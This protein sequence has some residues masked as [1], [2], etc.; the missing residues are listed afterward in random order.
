MR[1]F[2]FSVKRPVAVTMIV[3]IVVILGVVSLSRLGMDLF[4]A[5]ELPMLLIQTRYTGAGPQEIEEQVT[6]PLEAA[7]GTVGGVQ[8]ITSFSSRGS[9]MLLVEFDWGADLNYATNQMRDR[10]DMYGAALPSDASKPTIIKLDPSAMPIMQIGISGDATLEELTDYM[11]TRI[12]PY[13]ERIDGVASVNESGTVTEEI[14]VVTDPQRLQAYGVGMNQIMAVLRQENTNVSAGRVEEGL[15]DHAVRVV[16]EFT[17]I[18]DIRNLQIQSAYGGY[19]PLHSLAAIERTVKDR[20]SFV[21][22]N[23]KPGINVSLMKQ[24]DAN[25]VQTSARVRETID[26]LTEELPAGYEMFVAF[27]QADY[28][29]LSLSNVVSSALQGCALAVLILILFLRSWRST[30]IIAISIPVS[31]I[32]AFAMM[33]FTDVTLNMIS[34]GGLALGV[35]M[36]VDNSIVILENI[37]RFRQEEGANNLEASINGG[38]EVAGAVM[39]STITTIVVFLPIVFV[40]GLASQIFRQMAL[41]ITCSLLA[42]LGVSFIAVPMMS[43]K[44]LIKEKKKK[45]NERFMPWLK[46]WYSRFLAW[47]LR[48]KGVVVLFF[49]A[50]LIGSVFLLPYVGM[51]FI[52]AQ[53]TGEYSVSISLPRGVALRETLRV[54]GRVE[55]ILNEIPENER[56]MSNVGGGGGIMGLGLGGGGSSG[57]SFSGSLVPLSQRNRSIDEIMDDIRERLSVI[58]GIEYEVT[59]AGGMMMMMGSDIVIYLLGDD[60]EQLKVIADA[61]ARRLELIDGAREVSTSLE[62]G[63]PEINVY[64][65]RQKASQY[66]LN[67]STVAATVSAAVSGISPTK[68]RE[69][70]KELDVSLIMDARYRENLN[71]LEALTIASPIGNLIPLGN[72]AALSIETSPVSIVRQ[73]QS[74]QVSVSCT[75]AGRSLGDVASDVQRVLDGMNIPPEVRIDMGGSNRQMTDA[76]SDLY[77]ALALAVVLVYMVMAFQFEQ[78]LYPFVIMF[79]LPPTFIGVILCLYLTGRTLNV[80]SLIGVIMLVGIVVNNAIV[81]VDYI[82]VLRRVKGKNR[83]E[84]IVEAGLTRLRPIMMTSLTTIL[85]ML[86]IAIG[87]GEGQEMM[88]PLGT[89]VAGGLTFSTFITLIFVPCMY[90]Y[91]ENVSNGIRNIFRRKKTVTEG[92]DE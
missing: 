60:L 68:L 26:R 39:A 5:M 7:V 87:V 23:G 47:S 28:I 92:G 55:D 46:G 50:A 84:A 38:K 88:A 73:N 19:I 75:V 42:S 65:D 43:N 66:G 4:P 12:R 81:L 78:L 20:N 21:Y 80:V 72:I 58:P 83:E 85:A 40:E 90:V 13:L 49:T 37:F 18:E 54:A 45:E 61:V 16:G 70:G 67:S 35:G 51:E 33:Y 56:I 31:V 14:R 69:G 6:R 9:S 41:T 34:L 36:M 64:V 74:R 86:P 22:I 17:D 77:M 53:D 30:L 27:D 91:A 15:I 8:N 57:A 79:A 76:F 82:N 2:D 89:V 11:Q 1:I 29:N 32:A 25:L 48:H 63:N 71:D 62:T 3:L 10:L 24:S 52:P 44:L 59:S